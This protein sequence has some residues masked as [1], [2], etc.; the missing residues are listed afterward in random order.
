M[1]TLIFTG[2]YLPSAIVSKQ[3]AEAFRANEAAFWGFIR[4]YPI[5]NTFKG[6]THKVPEPYAAGYLIGNKTHD[7]IDELYVKYLCFAAGGSDEF[8][9]GIKKGIIEAKK[10]AN[11]W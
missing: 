1:A 9:E 4:F 8:K 3:R 2:V 10:E 6:I 11:R 7:F 5:Y